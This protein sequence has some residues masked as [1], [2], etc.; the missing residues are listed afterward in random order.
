MISCSWNFIWQHCFEVA[1]QKFLETRKLS[2]IH[3]QII[4]G[5]PARLPFFSGKLHNCFRVFVNLSN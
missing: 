4:H 3:I 5:V 2:T 1:E